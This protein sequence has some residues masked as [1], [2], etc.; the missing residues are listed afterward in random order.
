MAGPRG[1]RARLTAALIGLVVVAALVLGVGA[2]VFVE[3]RLHD[4]ALR[5]AEAQAGFDLAVT[6]PE[7]Q[8]PADPTLD[9]V[10]QSRLSETFAQRGTQVVVDLG[11]RGTFLSRSDLAG[12]LE[13]LPASMRGLVDDGQLAYAWTT[14]GDVPALVVGGR[15][16]GG[17]PSFYFVHEVG[18][19]QGAVDQL[20]LGL[21]VAAA[22][23]IG[24]ALVTA[25]A[26]AG[27]VLAPVDEASRA[28]DRIAAGDLSAR[29][30]VSS[31]D[32]FG[33]W[34]I[35]FNRMADTLADTI[36]R[37]EAAEEQNRRFV[38]DVSHEL[39]TPVAALV[40]EASVIDG[41]LDGLPPDIRR[42]GELLVADV[43]RLRTLVDDLM[44]LSRFD[45]AAETV[46][47][48][49]VDLARLVRSVAAARLPTA[50][51]VP[52]AA[53]VVVD[54]DPRRVERI[55][56]NLLDNARDHGE[57]R[58]V[59][60]SLVPGAEAVTLAVAD[61]GPGVPADRLDRIFERFSKL[62]PSRRRGSSGLGLAIAAEHAAV[63]GGHLE[64]S[65]RDGGGLRVVLVLPAAVA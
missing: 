24:L 34:A 65:L 16:A 18:E 9:D 31:Q 10:V 46:A 4:Q 48:E 32:E 50:R 47:V 64:A 41:H 27:G 43:R 56:G 15:P 8:L 12:L 33:E 59:E 3:G 49:P 37:L 45:A 39:R 13:G 42:A 36:A 25:R 1:V 28:A 20:R 63:L 17:G 60:I 40:A 5:E 44:E 2:T 54:T 30:P 14:V 7:R 52:P 19:I 6:V 61:R 21:A 51:F 26:I 11:A 57:G 29:V 23:L 35:R 53:A 55:L 58:D 22:I 62:D 38:A